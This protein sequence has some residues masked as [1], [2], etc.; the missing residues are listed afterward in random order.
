MR[1]EFVDQPQAR[2][3]LHAQLTEVLPTRTTQIHDLFILKVTKSRDSHLQKERKQRLELLLV[4]FSE[5]GMVALAQALNDHQLLAL[6][7]PFE[8]RHQ[9]SVLLRR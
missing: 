3:P 2:R 7:P 1:Y 6:I 4:S 9:V 5:T 8:Q